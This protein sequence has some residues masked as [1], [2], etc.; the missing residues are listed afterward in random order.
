MS[1][2]QQ[3]S[4]FVIIPAYNEEKNIA[5][6][7]A[8]ALKHIENIIVVDDGSKDATSKIAGQSPKKITV[9]RHKINLGKGAALKT[10]CEAAIKLGAKILIAM[11]G[12]N[13][14][15]PEDI[16]RLIDK[17]T[18]EELDIV[19]GS[20]QDNKN[21]PKIRLWGNKILTK[22][23]KILC[24]VK[25]SDVISG[26]RIFT[27]AAYKKLYWE[28][29]DYAVESE[30]VIKTG[31]YGLR[32]GEVPIKTIYMDNYKGMDVINGIKIL[33]KLL[34]FRFL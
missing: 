31:K 33:L 4:A 8:D 26:F 34:K 17:L 27:A 14:H 21:T 19:F 32:Y 9:L 13:Q 6:V 28:S 11:D 16:P 30:M 1:S 22:N 7:I 23:V 5:K 10:G 24:G 29:A 3:N 18:K 15:N 20:R 2:L 25:I 12:D